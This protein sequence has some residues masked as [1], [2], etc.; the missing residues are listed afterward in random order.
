[1]RDFVREH[2]DTIHDIAGGVLLAF[3]FLTAIA[4]AVVA[5]PRP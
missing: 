3:M 4:F 2:I 5:S 1:M